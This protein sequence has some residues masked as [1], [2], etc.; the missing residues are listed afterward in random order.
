MH[1]SRG[2]ESPGPGGRS[3]G[4]A[5]G[6]ASGGNRRRKKKPKSGKQGMPRER[7]GAESPGIKP[8]PMI[9]SNKQGQDT[10]RTSSER[11]HRQARPVSPGPQIKIKVRDRE[12]SANSQS[13]ASTSGSTSNAAGNSSPTHGS[14]KATTQ[15]KQGS[16]GE[17][18]GRSTGSPGRLY[19][20]G[21]RV[22]SGPIPGISIEVPIHKRLAAPPTMSQAVR[23]VDNSFLWVDGGTEYLLDQTDFLVVGVLGMQGSGKSTV[24]SLL[25]GSEHTDPCNS[26]IF[27]TQSQATAEQAGHQ[28]SG[29]DMFITEERI[30]LLDTQPV[31]SSSI[32]DRLLGPEKQV[33]PQ[34]FSSPEHYAEM[35][36]L[37]V[38][39]FLLT[40]CH[41]VLL[42]EDWFSDVGLME[43]LKRAEMLK[44]STP[45]PSSSQS[46]SSSA[47]NHEDFVPNIVFVQNKAGRESFQPIAVNAMEQSICSLMATSKLKYTGCS[48]LARS[49]VMPSLNSKTL[50]LDVNL[51]LLPA[52]DSEDKENTQPSKDTKSTLLRLVPDLVYRGHPKTELLVAAFRNQIYAASRPLITHTSLTEKNWF[53]YAGR[54]WESLKKSSLLLEYQRLLT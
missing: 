20:P 44:P 36:S 12:D 37:H 50:P 13:P 38:A 40:V 17:Q 33:V 8:P 6:G 34:E 26:F 27:E 4:G 7:G 11:P 51:F 42:V 23:L 46:E 2:G 53:Q 29:V 18:R 24:M 19:S 30:I 28:T 22:S 41:V 9:L 1:S 32:L 5:N 15:S 14:P 21:Q 25:A 39:A 45:P 16:D 48:S 52:F 31:L 10:E 35:Q 47:E 3:S 43:F 54:T 49:G